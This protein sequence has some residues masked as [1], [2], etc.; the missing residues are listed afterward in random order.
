MNV[1]NNQL[2]GFRTR[3][4]L[5]MSNLSQ[6]T[7]SIRHELLQTAEV[8]PTVL[9]DGL[10]HAKEETD[11]NAR[12]DLNERD[13]GHATHLHSAL[14]KITLGTYGCCERCEEPID[15]RR[16]TA[17][18]AA[19]LCVGCQTRAEKTQRLAQPTRELPRGSLFNRSFAYE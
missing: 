10:D 18:P 14:D 15:M 12:L 19:A 9:R 17:H 5:E 4:E 3:I 6:R 16:M 2:S 8:Q 1:T 7:N 13:I 11:I